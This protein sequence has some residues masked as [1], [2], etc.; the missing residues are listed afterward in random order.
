[1]DLTNFFNPRGIAVVGASSDSRKVGRQVLDSIIRNGYAGG[2][3]PINRENKT[4]AG[5]KA[6]A[7]LEMIPLKNKTAIL[8]VIV[9][10]APFVLGEIEKCV[11]LGIK[12]IIIISA[13]FKETG[14]EG[15]AREEEIN[16]L[17]RAHRLNIL[18]PNCLGFINNNRHLNASFADSGSGGGQI[19]VLSQ[20]GAIGSAILDW[21]KG[22]SFNLGYF[23]SLG[24]KAALN[25]N[26]FLTYLAKDKNTSAIIFYLE[27]IKN[28]QKFISLVSKVSLKKPV[29]VLK[30]GMSEQ[31]GAMAKSHTGAMA[32]SAAAVKA[33]LARAGAIMI[34]NLEELFDLLLILQAKGAY[35][36]ISSNLRILTNAGG[37]AVLSADE[38]S[39][40]K[41]I[42]NESLDILGDASAEK[43]E[44]A[45]DKMLR[46]SGND[47]VLVLL[48]PQ[49]ATE[50]LLT[51]KAIIKVDKKYSKRLVVASFLGDVAIDK[52]KDFLLEHKVPVFN[53]PERA[54]RAIKK[55]AD[56]QVA[57]K[58]L[59]PF[60]E[61][62]A[63]PGKTNPD[64]IEL[65][66]LL[67][68][69]KIPVVK[70]VKYISSTSKYNFP[71]VLKAVGPDFLHKTDKG[72]I[73]LNLNNHKELEK[74]ALSFS[75]KN[76]KF[77]QNKNNYLVVQP[78][79][80][81]SLEII[82]GFKRDISFGPLILVGIGGIYAEIFKEFRTVIADLNT[83]RANEF[84]KTLSFY[85]ILMGARGGKK[86]NLKQFAAILVTL[87]KLANE[88]P[89]IKEFDIN[90]LFLKDSG[91][92]AGDVRAII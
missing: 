86:Y 9:I 48:T 37:I 22:Q 88:H 89:E 44:K 65:F 34:E 62:K 92:L 6:F 42:L 25:E 91:A 28:G 20:S 4:I 41:L 73:M 54:I 74:A 31:G 3:F 32:G 75:K 27:D 2:I 71:V 8:V 26:D 15:M 29:I 81:G 58:I 40:Q 69:Y 76:I 13:G 61:A 10:P 16:K 21:L 39:R 5:R 52:A 55:L 70:T 79:I 33:G 53:Y 14:A 50:P 35:G 46:L 87:S 18:G 85:P 1:M 56:R 49:T 72:A 64:Y 19:A 43:Y 67:A 60:Y 84:V 68:K 38:V 66:K 23:V 90:P 47:N 17:A 59:T 45:L 24:N 82:L 80:E 30:S 36:Q 78:Q 12:N 11:R 51:A 63:V 77:L 83:K 7:S 57:L